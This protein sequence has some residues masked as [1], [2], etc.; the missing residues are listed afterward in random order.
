M[1]AD[2]YELLGVSRTASADEIKKAY[3]RRARDLHPDANPDDP[4]AAEQFKELSKAYAV[5]SDDQQRARY[6]QFGEAG[7]GGAGGPN[8]DDLFGGGLGDIFDAFF[9]GGGGGPF[10]GGRRG[11]SGPPRGQDMEVSVAITFEQSVFGDQIPVELKLPQAC[12][13]CDGSGAGENTKPVT[14]SECNG[15]GQVR[16]V[17]QS[18]L[19]QMVSS[20]PCPRC[21]GLGEVITTPCKTCR[22]EGRVTTDKTYHVDVP[23]GVVDGST[24]R[25]TRRGAV[26]PRGGSPGDLYVH[27]RVRPHDRYRRED[28]DL[29]TDVPISIAQ[30]ALGTKIAL[31]TLDGD[32]DLVVPAG[33]QPGHQFVLRGRGVPRLHGRGRGD[34]RAVV[35]VE[36]PTKLTSDEAD[37][38]RTF[39]E[40]RG[41]EVGE[42]G[43]SLF[44]KIKSAFS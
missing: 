37:L 15:S 25:L 32:E 26:G 44:S 16:R 43:S 20:S 38:L 2:Y 12:D 36:V 8:M 11:P 18:V 17:R 3:R 22:G 30:A 39:A 42:A 28:D 34:L 4:Q 27:L 21:G 29:V 6:D 41:E 1:A 31:A 13:D 10:G 14:C 35:D 5:L 23:A 24:L 33:T 9:G 40:G 7:V 19:G